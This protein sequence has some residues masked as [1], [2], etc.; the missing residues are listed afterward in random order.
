M[1]DERYVITTKENDEIIK[2]FFKEGPDGPLSHFPKKQKMKLA[3]LRHIMKR[4]DTT[5]NYSEKEVN[6]ILRTAD[7]DYVTLRRYLIEYGFIDRKDD[8]S[9]YWVK[10]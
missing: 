1:V 2:K 6:E 4:F 9:L 5:K 8:G 3:I 10:E 7:A